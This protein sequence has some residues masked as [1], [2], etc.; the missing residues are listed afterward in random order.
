MI[1]CWLSDFWCSLAGVYL[2][3]WDSLLNIVDA[4]LTALGPISF[5]FP[6]IASEYAWIFGALGLSQALGIF[7]VAWTIRFTLQMIP[8]V[9][10][11]S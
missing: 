6:T 9:R 7:V 8:F 1:Y 4:S 2:S 3:I 11:G 10:W 5:E